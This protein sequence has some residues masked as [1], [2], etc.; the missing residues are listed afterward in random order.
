MVRTV[1][2]A[3]R[4]VHRYEDVR[5]TKRSFKPAVFVPALCAMMAQKHLSVE[6]N[7][8][9]SG[10][11]RDVTVSDNSRNA[12]W[13]TDLSTALPLLDL[14]DNSLSFC[15]SGTM[16]RY[17]ILHCQN[18]LELRKFSVIVFLPRNERGCVRNNY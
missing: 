7:S 15:T 14:I 18:S 6:Q 8:G 4:V 11:D 9:A 3:G 13:R 17:N 5:G 10:G 2:D 16:P 12:R 1:H